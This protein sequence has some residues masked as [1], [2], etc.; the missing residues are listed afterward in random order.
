MV[1]AKDKSGWS[2]EEQTIE[3]AEENG[4]YIINDPEIAEKI[5]SAFPNFDFIFDEN[6][7]I[8]DIS[9]DNAEDAEKP[10][11][12]YINLQQ[13]ISELESQN[14]TIEDAMLES[15]IAVNDRITQIEDALI[16]LDEQINGGANNG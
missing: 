13:R 6:G 16:E 3:W 4:Y 1:V 9:T 8:I 5:K 7:N 11:P 14:Q 2:P 10:E 15:D 12:V